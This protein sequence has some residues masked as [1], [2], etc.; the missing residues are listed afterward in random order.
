MARLTYA[1]TESAPSSIRET[2]DRHPVV[3]LRMLAHA[4]GAFDTW[5]EYTT[6][7]LAES[8]V[9]PLLRELAIL[10]LSRLRGSEYQWLQHAALARAVG[11][12]PD[13]I[14]AIKEGREDDSSL[15]EEQREV[16]RLSREITLEGE[17]GEE[18]VAA[19]AA[20]LGPRQLVELVLV[21]GHW[22]AI[23]SLVG[24][25]GLQPDLPAMAGALP[26]TLAL[27]EGPS[28]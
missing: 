19:V 27:G 16:L 7:L 5:M 24:T 10:E 20:R 4:E 17:A 15:T 8:E 11:A 22:L 9:D 28:D 23:C 18:V 6:A 1:D 3:F 26:H 14:A 13:Q 12:S 21:T 25:F 2:L